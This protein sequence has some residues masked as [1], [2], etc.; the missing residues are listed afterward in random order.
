LAA[1]QQKMADPSFA[2]MPPAEMDRLINRMTVLTEQQIKTVTA[3]DYRAEEAEGAGRVRLLV[4]LADG[5]RRGRHR[6][7]P[8]RQER[9][10]ERRVLRL[11]GTAARVS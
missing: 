2:K 6:T 5:E 9:R 8:M 1:I 7:C 11:T 4:A 10:P 3:P